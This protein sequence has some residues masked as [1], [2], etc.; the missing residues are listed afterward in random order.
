MAV[1]EFP[2]HPNTVRLC[3][4]FELSMGV[5]AP[6][7]NEISGA[8]NAPVSESLG[9]FNTGFVGWEQFCKKE[10]ITSSDKIKA[11]ART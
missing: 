6:S 2:D 5:S 4:Q 11:I 8:T 7:S 10:S 3:R 9:L 1:V